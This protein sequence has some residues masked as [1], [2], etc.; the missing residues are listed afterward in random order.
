MLLNIGM[1]VRLQ[2][3]NLLGRDELPTLTQSQS[4]SVTVSGVGQVGL[5]QLVHG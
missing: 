4:Q 2:D 3:A 1:R 5:G